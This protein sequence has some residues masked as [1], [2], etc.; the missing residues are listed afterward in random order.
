M[1]G[2][3]DSGIG[4][5]SV[6]K[7]IVERLPGV[8]TIYIGDQANAPYG[9]KTKLEIKKRGEIISAYLISQGARIIVVACNTA[10][11]SV[12]IN[13]LRKLFPRT[14]FVGVEPPV[15]PLATLTK[16]GKIAI[17]ATSL[18]CKS[19]RLQKLINL[20][21]KHLQVYVTP[22]PEWVTLVETGDL[23]SQHAQNMIK[24]YTNEHLKL[25]VDQAGLGC[26]HYP[27]LRST[28]EK[29]TEGKIKF[30]DIGLPVA[31]RVETLLSKTSMQ[32]TNIPPTHQFITTSKDKTTLTNALE[33]LLK[34]QAKVESINI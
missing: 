19:K 25:G 15:K 11:V 34:I 18:T 33:N 14:Q 22:T 30:I 13:H 29:V 3:F 31:K 7:E 24:K 17:Y 20:H 16:T 9:I 4:G 23:T 26:T 8:S 2:I 5:L 1:I 10:T 6:Y 12:T 21:A 28:L 32:K 27:F